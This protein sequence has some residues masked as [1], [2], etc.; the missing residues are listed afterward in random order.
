[1]SADAS[2][3][4]TAVAAPQAETVMPLVVR[5][6]GSLP[7]DGAAIVSA[8]SSARARNS[9]LAS[10][11]LS[12][13]FATSPD[14]LRRRLLGPWSEGLRQ[15]L[16]IRLGDLV[17]ADDALREL[18]R[19]VTA[20]PT[21]ELVLD[22]GPK[23]RVYRLARRVARD[24]LERPQSAREAPVHRTPGD[25]DRA[26]LSAL[27]AL[28][29]DLGKD[30]RELLELRHAR[31]LVPVEL[32]CVLERS[33][34]E[35][36]QSL[37][38]AQREAIKL[39]G[40]TPFSPSLVVDAYALVGSPALE[41]RDDAGAEREG[42]AEGTLVGGRYRV[43][44]R[45][46]V[47][48]F[49]EVYKADDQDVPGHRVAL[50]VLR[51][52]ALSQAARDEALRELKLI[53]AVFHP[54]VVLFKD[55]GWFEDRLWFVMP[56]YEGETLEVRMRRTPEG[57]RA[58]L[59]RAQARRIFEPLARALATLHGSGV[60]HQDIK[61]DNVFLARI[62]GLAAAGDE[63]GILPVLIDLG[64]A[65]KEHEALIG[66][67]PVYFAPE[68]AAHYAQVGS[69]VV[70]PKAD[71][72]ALALSL[73]N[74]L[75]PETEEDVPAGAVEAFIRRRA[76][77]APPL[78]TRPDLAFLRPY[79]ARWLAVDPDQ[80]PSA[81]ELAKELAV[82]TRPEERRAQTRKTLA[83]LV[84]MLASLTAIFT[85]V[86][87]VY[88]RESELQRQ[89]IDEARM[90]VANVRADL[91]VEEARRQSLDQD[92]A[93]LMQQYEEGRL[94]R[95]ELADQL[96]TAQ[97]QIEILGG[98]IA[99]LIAERDQ[100]STDI[101]VVRARLVQT[102]TTLT[103]TAGLLREERDERRVAETQLADARAE[104]ERAQSDFDDELAAAQIRNDALDDELSRTRD[105]L[106]Q[107]Q[108][109]MHA[110]EARVSVA[111]DER[112]DAR[113]DFNELERR[114]SELRQMLDRLR[115]SSDDEVAR[116]S[117][118]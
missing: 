75:E 15:Y 59:T 65:A 91:L 118:P 98:R 102:E 17:A 63:A 35:V 83:W 100:I 39:I 40:A 7:P 42:V 82:L 8:T 60:R 93:Q 41:R 50:K 13:L 20:T 89:E 47:G 62:K 107:A 2:A 106:D 22:P 70:G 97:G 26:Y 114:V 46:G 6:D 53:A 72:F 90:E 24:R 51:E 18:R 38:E 56:W 84:P 16:A 67:T 55:H 92:H 79:F 5:R 69:D 66:G 86:V 4:K 87:Y 78:P 68:V 95:S 74:A 116:G 11:E 27:D 71:V 81:E 37:A 21:S 1:M 25:V 44:S 85:L 96:A 88:A 48:A 19:L 76:T 36:E 105:D 52:P 14:A 117:G 57:E 45:V 99:S 64:V 108:A 33:E 109:R 103:S 61:P 80:R 77:E 104:H 58:G 101:V 32:A 113:R 12:G 115:P 3:K 28:R 94:S 9:T 110:L 31:E 30:A 111:E 29:V 73:R 23:A 10:I 34:A 54:S 112:D 49:G 43:V